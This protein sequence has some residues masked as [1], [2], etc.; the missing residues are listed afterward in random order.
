VRD[1]GF[2]FF[3]FGRF[4]RR[5][6]GFLY[7][8]GLILED[9]YHR[10]PTRANKK[11][12]R[13]C[14]SPAVETQLGADVRKT[15]RVR[16]GGVKVKLVKAKSANVLVGGKYVK[17]EVTW[18]ADNPASRDLTRRNIITKGAVIDVKGPDGAAFKAKVIS[19]PGQD[20]V[21]NAIKV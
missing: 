19:R 4:Y 18:V 10:I 5:M 17:C 8:S 6:L 20:G 12:S 21:L 7:A 11:K 15:V 2:G 1:G 3:G 13:F 16:G 14:G 9:M